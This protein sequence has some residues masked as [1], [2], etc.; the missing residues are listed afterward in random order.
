MLKNEDA[1][2]LSRLTTGSAVWGDVSGGALFRGGAEVLMKKGDLFR[3][4][5]RDGDS[6]LM[7]QGS[8]AAHLFGSLRHG[9]F[10]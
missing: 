9:R 8:G 5:I 4:A 2:H 7:T 3:T 10:K 6:R 1:W